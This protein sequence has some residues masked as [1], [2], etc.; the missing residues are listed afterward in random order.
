LGEEVCGLIEEISRDFPGESEKYHENFILEAG[1]EGE[2]R[3]DVHLNTNLKLYSFTSLIG[4]M[5]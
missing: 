3:S 5:R 1:V 4:H 2:I